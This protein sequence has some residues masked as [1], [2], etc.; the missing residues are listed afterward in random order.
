MEIGESL[1]SEPTAYPMLEKDEYLS[2]VCSDFTQTS[3]NR[4]IAL[5][6][7]FTSGNTNY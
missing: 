2:S 6:S 5:K 4:I 3:V 1:I 7:N